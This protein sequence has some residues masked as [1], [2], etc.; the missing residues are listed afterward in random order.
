MAAQRIECAEQ[1]N[2]EKRRRRKSYDDF[3]QFS[4]DGTGEGRWS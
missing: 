4:A 1:P 3:E 2:L